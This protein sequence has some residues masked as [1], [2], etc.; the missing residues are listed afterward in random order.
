MMLSPLAFLL[1]SPALSM[2]LDQA[3]DAAADTSPVAQLSEARVAEAQAQ[4]RQATSYL[5]PQLS[6]AGGSIWQNEVAMSICYPIYQALQAG[7][8]EVYPTMCD[9][10]QDPVIMPGQQ[11]QWQLEGQQALLAPQAWL[12]RRAA[13]RGEAMAGE[14]GEA[15]L[16]QLESYVVEAWHA[17]ARHQA[18]LEDAV[19]AQELAAHIATLAATLVDNGVATRDQVL[20][21]EGALATARATVARANAASQA[22]DSA[23]ALLTGREEPADAFT[24]PAVVP[25]LE[26]LTSSLAR[27]DLALADKQVEAAEAMVWAERG[28]AMPV[29]GLSGKVFGLDPAPLIYDDTNWNVMVGVT[30]PLVRGGQVMAK[31]D[32]A[33]AQVDK[34]AAGR[35]LVRDQA[36]LEVIRVHG[37]LNA[38][39]ASL[40][41]REQA[42]SLAE[43]AVVAAEARLKEGAGSMLDLQ[44]A[45]GGVAEARVRLTLAKADAAYANDKLRHVTGML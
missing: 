2:S 38:A 36:K 12:Y 9:D 19:A 42:L 8:L 24:I 17:S 7:G 40:T 22:A 16:F 25:T 34:A 13:Q 41:E 18:L 26:D 37:E 33:Q 44:M 5:L 21:A 43:E 30:V 20:Q 28:A 3:L 11:W 39:M 29:V 15:D 45:Q 31:V 27:P 4:V 14:Q 6:A 10:F 35:R 32:Q 1:V 23:L